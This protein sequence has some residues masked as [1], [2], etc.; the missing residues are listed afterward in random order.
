LG[1]ILYKTVEQ[2][3]VVIVDD[4]TGVRAGIRYIL[5]NASDI[6]IVG[7]G[8]NGVD[9]IHLASTYKPN[10]IL[11]DVELPVLNGIEAARLIRGEH[12]DVKILA[13]S[14]YNDRQ[15]IIEMIENGAAGYITK[16]EVPELLVEA[17]RTVYK[18]DQPWLS[19]QANKINKTS[20]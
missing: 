3:R 18:E 14:S 16:D 7:E 15:Y 4:H 13:V 17:V 8:A 20:R 5:G 19:P 2:I 12:S 9:A 10:V 1:E 6:D 11:L